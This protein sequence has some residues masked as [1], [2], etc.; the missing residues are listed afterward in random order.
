MGTTSR[1]ERVCIRGLSYCVHRWPGPGRRV[2][3]LHGL[4]D[5][6]ASFAPLVDALVDALAENQ[7]GD[8]DLIAPDWRGHGDSDAAREGY[9]FPDYV[10]DLDALINHYSSAD[11]PVVVVGHS[12]GGQVA[13]LYAGLRPA[14]VAAL[15]LLDCLNIPAT[16]PAAI[17]ERYRAWLDA[18]LAPPAPKV[19]ASVAELAKRVA[20]R[21]P[22]LRAEQV[23]ALA[24]AWARPADGGVR[25]ANDPRH[26]VPFPMGFH[27][28][29]AMA[30]WRQ[31]RA[32]VLYLE[33]GES[34]AQRWVSADDARARRA[35]FTQLSHELLPGRAH[36]LHLE[37]VAEVAAHIRAFVAGAAID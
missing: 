14:R 32:P 30:V 24:Q 21:Y 1:T 6:G 25:L 17:P 11:E 26:R 31:V 16:D 33:G 10:A 5:T 2:F 3:L 22:E 18:Q 4:L 12:M 7:G 34:P 15:V 13:S 28:E 29:D 35:C 19:Y 37:A 36:M 9:W 8:Y 23:E 27:P 20:R